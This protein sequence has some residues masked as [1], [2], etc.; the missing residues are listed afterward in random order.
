MFL[1]DMSPLP[2]ATR[3]LSTYP[4]NVPGTEVRSF[5]VTLIEDELTAVS[6]MAL[7]GMAATKRGKGKYSKSVSPLDI[8]AYTSIHHYTMWTTATGHTGIY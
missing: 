5:Q 4:S 2:S 3:Y 8:Q 1:Y 7:G 6:M